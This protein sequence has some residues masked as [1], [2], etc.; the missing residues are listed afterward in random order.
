[1]ATPSLATQGGL[2]FPV[3]YP[4]QISH[5][6]GGVQEIET[7]TN[8]NAT[9]IEVGGGV[10]RGAAPAAG[11]SP[12]FTGNIKPPVSGGVVIGFSLRALSEMNTAVSAGT[13]NYPQYSEV[14]VMREGLMWATAA[15]NAA[16]GEACI[17]V[18]ATPATVGSATTGGAANG[19]TRLAAPAVW[20]QAVVAGQVGL[21]SVKNTL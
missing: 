19:T 6:P 4:G 21:I 3:G 5:L 13:V 11:A 14:P 20:R 1:M 10:C 15:E 9:P 7:R 12:G 8:E 2:E 16:E 17:I 18:V